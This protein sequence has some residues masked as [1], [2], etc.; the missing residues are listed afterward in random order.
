MGDRKGAMRRVERQ[1]S[2]GCGCLPRAWFDLRMRGFF[3]A[4]LWVLAG[5]AGA[6]EPKEYD[7]VVYGGTPGGI[8]AAVMG[9]REGLSVQLL[10]VTKHLGGMTSGGLSHTDVGPKPEIL[11]GFA[12]EFYTRADAK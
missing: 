4:T 6:E 10:E 12:R 7:L 11:G 2:S 9:A 5:C 3:V 8:A 1:D